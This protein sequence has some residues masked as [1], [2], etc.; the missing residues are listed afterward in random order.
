[1]RSGYGAIGL[2]IARLLSDERAGEHTAKRGES[3]DVC[4]CTVPVSHAHNTT[5]KRVVDAPAVSVASAA[6]SG[7]TAAGRPMAR[8][9]QC[10]D[11]SASK[12]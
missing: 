8:P 12:T 7:R 9:V 5:R 2:E 4:E 6:S 3:Q 1:M 11:E 10:S